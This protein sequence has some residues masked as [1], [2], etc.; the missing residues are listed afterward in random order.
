MGLSDL[1][2]SSDS[3]KVM[4]GYVN[5]NTTKRNLLQ[6]IRPVSLL[7]IKEAAMKQSIQTI[8]QRGPKRKYLVSLLAVVLVVGVFSGFAPCLTRPYISP[9]SWSIRA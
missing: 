9:G 1:Y 5:T 7:S 6:M 4:Y 3:A 8:L 2:G